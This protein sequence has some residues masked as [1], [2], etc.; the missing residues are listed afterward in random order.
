MVVKRIKASPATDEPQSFLISIA[1]IMVGVL[2]F[3]II[4]L[5]FF[6]LKLEHAATRGVNLAASLR[7]TETVRA[8]VLASLQS[9]LASRGIQ[10]TTNP[11]QGVLSLPE[12]ILFDKNKAELSRHGEEVGTVLAQSLYKTLVCYTGIPPAEC[13]GTSPAIEEALIEGHTDG[14]GAEVMIWS[15]SVKR[16]FNVFQFLMATNPDLARLTNRNQQTIFS[17]AG[18]GKLRPLLPG[19]TG[20]NKRMNGRIDIHLIMM[21]PEANDV[22]VTP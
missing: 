5:I 1:D 22:R 18:Y 15:L 3:F 13:S 4:A 12:S 17:I 10:A 21:P 2:F 6:A 9:D 14:D 16:S 19:D 20:E 8:N 7:T 11:R